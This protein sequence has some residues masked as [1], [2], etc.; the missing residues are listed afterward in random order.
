METFYVVYDVC[1]ATL[2]F[3]IVVVVCL[4]DWIGL[5]FIIVGWLSVF[6]RFWLF[7]FVFVLN[8]CN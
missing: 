6:F 7:V 4:F 5:L 1:F 2:W 3:I 8:T